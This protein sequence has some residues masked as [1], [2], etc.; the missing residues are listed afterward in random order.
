MEYIKNLLSKNLSLIVKKDS[1]IIFQSSGEMLHDLLRCIKTHKKEIKNALVVDKVV[2]LA[3]AR[4]LVFAR[5][6]EVYAFIASE[7]AIKYLQ[8]R[9]IAIHAKRI[10][11]NILNRDKT[12]ICPME[13]RALNCRSDSEFYKLLSTSS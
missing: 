11:K 8:K 9:N 2:G 10:V 7:P 12:G 6:K 1:K 4:L 3:A 13:R 5:V